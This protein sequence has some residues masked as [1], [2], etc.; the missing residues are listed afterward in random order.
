[1]QKEYSAD[2]AFAK[3]LFKSAEKLSLPTAVSTSRNMRTAD[4]DCSSHSSP[5]TAAVV[6]TGAGVSAGMSASGASDV[7]DGVGEAFW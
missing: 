3:E 4:R 2:S 1:L 7:V 5:T 6:D